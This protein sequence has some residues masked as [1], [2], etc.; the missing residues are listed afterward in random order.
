MLVN[1]HKNAV[2]LVE[3]VS[4]TF[5]CPMNPPN[6]CKITV[7]VSQNRTGQSTRLLIHL[8]YSQLSL[9]YSRNANTQ[10]G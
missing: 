3:L 7:Y 9:S 1:G 6:K 10:G 2:E 8:V 5:M 4:A